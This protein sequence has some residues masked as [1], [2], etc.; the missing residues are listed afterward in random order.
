MLKRRLCRMFIQC[1]FIPCR[2]CSRAAAVYPVHVH[3]PCL[4]RWT[5]MCLL[6]RANTQA[7]MREPPPGGAGV[8]RGG[9]HG[10]AREWDS[11][12]YL[13]LYTSF[14]IAFLIIGKLYTFIYIA[15]S[16]NLHRR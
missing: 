7:G 10:V 13:N 11:Y 12:I 5:T 9:W 1:A 8:G 16:N 2:W 3:V 14:H 15:N 6:R 4:C